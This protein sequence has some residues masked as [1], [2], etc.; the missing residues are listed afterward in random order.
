MSMSRT[1]TVLAI[2]S[3][4]WPLRYSFRRVPKP[5]IG[6][7][8]TAQIG[9]DPEKRVH[10][11]NISNSISAWFILRHGIRLK[12]EANARPQSY[13]IL[14]LPLESRWLTSA[15][16][17]I[18]SLTHLICAFELA[19]TR[20][21]SPSCSQSGCALA[22]RSIFNKFLSS[23]NFA[24]FIKLLF[25][26]GTAEVVLLRLLLSPDLDDPDFESP[27]IIMRW[28]IQRRIVMSDKMS[29]QNLDIKS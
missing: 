13:I 16:A 20:A 1:V 4:S 18:S 14:S 10:F 5:I 6:T 27:A 17:F 24:Y 11:N 29:D 2:L 15:P 25:R 21:D 26:F 8:D 3:T 7:S 23:P 22:D 28:R 9:I 12:V 19:A